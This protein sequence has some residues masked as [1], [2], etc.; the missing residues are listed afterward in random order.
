MKKDKGGEV[1][2]ERKK[3]KGKGPKTGMCMACLEN[4]RE[5]SVWSRVRER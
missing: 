4:R 5:A 1:V 3:S 2:G